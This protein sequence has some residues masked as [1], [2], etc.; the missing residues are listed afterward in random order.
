MASKLLIDQ[1]IVVPFMLLG[2]FFLNE[3][4]QL[5]GIKGV[6]ERI[7]EDFISVMKGNL[8]VWPPAMLL[9]FYFVPLVLRTIFVRLVSFF[10]NIYLSWKAHL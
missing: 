2:F 4:L 7:Q 5:N 10:W 1:L 6:K 8:A 3:I 9:N